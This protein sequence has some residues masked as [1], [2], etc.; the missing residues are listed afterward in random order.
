MLDK[1]LINKDRKYQRF[2]C[3]K[4]NEEFSV[5][6]P[7]ADFKED[8]IDNHFGIDG[9]IEV[10]EN[11]SLKDGRR[12]I[13]KMIYH[14]TLAAEDE[15]RILLEKHKKKYDKL[16]DEC[17]EKIREYDAIEYFKS[18]SKERL[19][20]ILEQHIKPSSSEEHQTS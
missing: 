2:I 16:F 3:N 12:S 6:Q 7:L 13:N 20:N 15:K 17:N 1:P 8:F 4:T 5:K 9:S 11:F 10:P 18:I 14:I 19:D